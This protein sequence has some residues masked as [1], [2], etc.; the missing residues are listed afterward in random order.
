MLS[1][2]GGY[3]MRIFVILILCIMASCKSFI[4]Q[5]QETVKIAI[6]GE[7]LSLDPY[8]V[9]DGYSLQIRA[10]IYNTL[11]SKN[12]NGEFIGELAKTWEYITPTHIRFI[13]QDEVYF[14]NGE[15]LTPKDVKYTLERQKY[16]IPNKDLFSA[17]EKIEIGSNNVDLYLNKPFAPLLDHL[18][19]PNA[20][21]VNQYAIQEK[22]HD[23]KE[24]PIGTGA[25]R[26]AEWKRGYSISLVA[27]TNYF[28]SSPQIEKLKFIVIP[29]ENSRTISLENG[30]IDIARDISF[31]E[32]ERLNK[33]NTLEII[34]FQT[35]IVT[36]LSINTKNGIMANKKVRQ[37]I[38]LALDREGMINSIFFG[39]ARVA[40]TLI[41]FNAFGY[42]N[43]GIK[44]DLDQ[45]RKIIKEQNVENSTLLLY[46]LG[47]KHLQLAEI[48][49]Y[50]L[51]MIGLKIK[52]QTLE[53]GTFL[54]LIE[55]GKQDLYLLNWTTLTEDGDFAL[56]QLLSEESLWNNTGYI[57]QDI[58]EKLTLARYEMNVKKR[59]KLY[60]DIQVILN[61]DLPYIPL[62]NITTVNGINS[63]F[64]GVTIV[65]GSSALNL[66]NISIK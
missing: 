48:I 54:R 36:Y 64:K 20:Y 43:I 41:P 3:L 9:L 61:E 23:M 24:S 50:N 51:H 18:S 56:T 5:E 33:D 26:F 34:E 65:G 17:I 14:H 30:E 44:T 60:E 31:S 49:Q 15:K 37:A 59:Q 10:Q 22:N 27:H 53:L 2:N 63:I 1:M 6:S 16:S 35:P 12:T 11:I 52:I 25:Y 55:K 28:L 4:A 62:I 39:K 19:L 66:Q 38:S 7:P 45:A 21:I 13:L 42:T 58:I 57:N 29:E 46:T 47:G 8:D 32:I 40:D